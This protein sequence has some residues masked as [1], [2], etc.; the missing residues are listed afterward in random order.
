MFYTTLF[1]LA[2]LVCFMAA[3]I[4]GWGIAPWL[5]MVTS[6]GFLAM[7]VAAG[8]LDSTYGRLILA[9]LFFSWWGDLFLISGREKIFLMGLVAFLL[10][11]LVFAGAF[12]SHGVDGRWVAGGFLVA[13][14]SAAVIFPW[15]NPHL[16]DMRYPVY[17]YM[18]V[19][20]AMVVASVGAWGNGATALVLLGAVLFYLSDICVARARF[21]SPGPWN[22]YIGLPLYYVAQMLLATSIARVNGPQP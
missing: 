14:G 1:T 12:V 3:T 4:L 5:K 2:S 9:A 18:L 15:L 19:I 13:V 22:G 7:A 8:G 17:A 6:T 21:V 11:H 10:G 20:S 16:G